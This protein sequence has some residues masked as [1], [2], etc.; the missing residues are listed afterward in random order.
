[1]P[2]VDGSGTTLPDATV[3]CVFGSDRG[4]L[5]VPARTS[6]VGV[7]RFTGEGLDR[8]TGVKRR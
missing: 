3:S 1:M 2:G 8:V 5:V 7:M 4:E 6:A